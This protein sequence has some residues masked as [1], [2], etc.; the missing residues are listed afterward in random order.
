MKIVLRD[1]MIFYD[2][3]VASKQEFLIVVERNRRKIEI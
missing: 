1:E 3:L 2:A